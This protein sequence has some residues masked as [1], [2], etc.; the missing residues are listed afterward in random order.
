MLLKMY[1][2]SFCKVNYGISGTGIPTGSII[3]G[4]TET[5]ITI[6]NNAT[7]TGTTVSLKIGPYA[8][9]INLRWQDLKTVE[10]FRE[11][12]YRHN[13]G[14]MYELSDEFY[15]DNDVDIDSTFM[16]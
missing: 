11:V 13:R 3:T 4:F 12:C 9:D 1:L 5:T 16:S 8:K 6:N 10:N 15:K 14:K 2:T 7:E